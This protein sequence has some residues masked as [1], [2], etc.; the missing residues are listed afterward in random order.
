MTNDCLLR[1][2]KTGRSCRETITG[3]Y[4]RT[5]RHEQTSRR[6]L[7]LPTDSSEAPPPKKQRFYYTNS[8]WLL[9]TTRNGYVYAK[10]YTPIMKSPSLETPDPREFKAHHLSL[11]D[12]L[13]TTGMIRKTQKNG[14]WMIDDDDYDEIDD[15]LCLTRRPGRRTS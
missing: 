7:E 3:T 5:C 2:Q 1:S 6:R 14:S 10:G 8:S 9:E 4:I 13:I 12:Q 15:D 11:P